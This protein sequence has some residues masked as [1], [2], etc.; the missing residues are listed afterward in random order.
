MSIICILIPDHFSIVCSPQR[1]TDDTCE[2]PPPIIQ[3]RKKG[4][5]KKA[6]RKGKKR[7]GQRTL[8]TPNTNIFRQLSK[9]AIPTEPK[10]EYE[11]SEIEMAVP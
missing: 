8:M 5:R 1:F 7:G 11:M 6:R 4:R 10:Y 3:P 9:E 2:A